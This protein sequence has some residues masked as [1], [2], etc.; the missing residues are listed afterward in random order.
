MVSVE[1][2][3]DLFEQYETLP[4]EVQNIISTFVDETYLECE[5]LLKE[6]EPY[7]YTFEY[8]LDAQPYNL[9]KIGEL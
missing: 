5:R 8:G 9:H 1:N 6:L 2:S 4:K 3:V 7:G